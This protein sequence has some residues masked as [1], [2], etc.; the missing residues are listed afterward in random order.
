VRESGGGFHL[1]DPVAAS[2][3]LEFKSRPSYC[4]A[5]PAK[6]P[7]HNYEIG[8]RVEV[9][10]HDGRIME[11]VVK[12]VVDRTD[13]KRLQVDYGKDETALVHL[14]QVRPVK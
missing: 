13:G 8:E 9:T 1:Q 3:W 7:D 10:L 14:W 11:G 6:K 5:V 12:A 2:Y 4:L